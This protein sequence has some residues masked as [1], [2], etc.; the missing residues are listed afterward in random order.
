MPRD[1]SPY[2]LTQLARHGYDS[3]AISKLAS[4]IDQSTPV[5][6]ITGFAP[7]YGSDF[8][9]TADTLIPREESEQLVTMALHRIQASSHYPAQIVDVGTGSGALGLT[10][11]RLLTQR[12]IRY[13]TTL[14]DTS[15]RALQIAEK[16]REKLSSQLDANSTVRIQHSDLLESISGLHDLI[17]ANLP[18]IPRADYDGLQLS[19][20]DHEPESALVGGNTGTELIRRLLASAR[21][22]LSPN[23]VLL[24]EIDASHTPAVLQP[25]ARAHGWDCKLQRDHYDRWRYA[26]L[27]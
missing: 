27:R 8:I 17:I 21:A 24:L 1:F 14:C 15:T 16:N 5:E 22:K 6:H 20:R 12:D 7:F 18:Y 26:T 19:V 3:T 23:G 11:S 9:V 13:Y 4:S 25:L 2:E 10:L